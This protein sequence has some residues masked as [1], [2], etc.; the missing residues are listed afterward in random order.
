VEF[1]LKNIGAIGKLYVFLKSSVSM[2][3]IK[4]G[5][6]NF[7]GKNDLCIIGGTKLSSTRRR[8]SR[9]FINCICLKAFFVEYGVTVTAVF[10]LFVTSL[11]SQSICDT[12]E[13][14]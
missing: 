13:T 7:P 12:V 1:T 4:R 11:V 2:P 5:H 14:T 9:P 10:A 3:H 6:F 8:R